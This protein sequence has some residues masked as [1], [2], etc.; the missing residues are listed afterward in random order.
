[1]FVV[2][3]RRGRCHGVAL[4]MEYSLT[5]DITVSMGLTEPVNGEV[6]HGILYFL[7]ILPVNVAVFHTSVCPYSTKE[8]EY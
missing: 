3:T 4:W 7:E 8:I 1:M 6:F 2:F 5:D